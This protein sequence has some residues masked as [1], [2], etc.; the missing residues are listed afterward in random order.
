MIRE[1]GWCARYTTLTPSNL[2][3]ELMDSGLFTILAT[4]RQEGS[5]I[6]AVTDSAVVSGRSSLDLF[7]TCK[8]S[9]R[10]GF[11]T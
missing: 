8:T 10:P 7:A 11:I 9:D 5:I 1:H 4:Y 3:I 2:L 6:C